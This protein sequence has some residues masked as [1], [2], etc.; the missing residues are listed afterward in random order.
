ML[1]RLLQLRIP[2]EMWYVSNEGEKEAE[3][4]THFE[5]ALVAEIVDILGIF[6][7]LTVSLEKAG[8]AAIVHLLP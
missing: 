3:K 4:L 2:I 6:K 1:Q 7:P 8:D 5:W